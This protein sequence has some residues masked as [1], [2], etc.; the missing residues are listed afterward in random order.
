MKEQDC[1]KNKSIPQEKGN[2]LFYKIINRMIMGRK[3]IG[4]TYLAYGTTVLCVL[5]ARAEFLS[6]TPFVGSRI[7]LL[8][9]VCFSFVYGTYLLCTKDRNYDSNPF[10]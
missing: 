5:A 4:I 8:L 3:S 9:S 6:S 1:N 2:S 10:M 7:C